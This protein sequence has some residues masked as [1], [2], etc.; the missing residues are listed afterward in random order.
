MDRSGYISAVARRPEIA[1]S[2]LA[3]IIAAKNGVALPES[4]QIARAKEKLGPSVACATTD[5]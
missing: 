2:I 3:E 5:V 1:I 4:V